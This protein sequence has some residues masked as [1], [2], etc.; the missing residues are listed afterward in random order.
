MKHTARPIA[1]LAPAALVAGVLLAPLA[2]AGE[3]AKIP[4]L[5]GKWVGENKTLSPQKGFKVWGEKTIEITEQQDRRFRGHFT[6]PAGTKHFVG[7]IYPDNTT[8]TWVAADSKG[9]NHGH[10]FDGDHISACYVE[11][12]E[13]ATVGCAELTRKK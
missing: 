11:S 7:I 5:V 8:I 4:N 12:G 3:P 13:D 6:Y 2:S 1:L 9:Y 10:I